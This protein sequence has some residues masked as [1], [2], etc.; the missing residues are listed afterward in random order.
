[1]SHNPYSPPVAAVRDPSGPGVRPHQPGIVTFTW[2]MAWLTLALFGFA[3]VRFTWSFIVYWDHAS[4]R[5]SDIAQVALRAALTALP[6]STLILLFRHP[7][8][9][10]WTGAL[11]IASYLMLPIYMLVNQPTSSGVVI[12]ALIVAGPVCVWLR[13]FAFSRKSRAWFNWLPEPGGNG[14]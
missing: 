2:I 3:L 6:V 14:N 4:T 5:G 7:R 12:G 11:M 10:R 13:A 1:V 9:G 8:Y